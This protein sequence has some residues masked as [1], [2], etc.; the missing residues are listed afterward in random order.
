MGASSLV[1]CNTKPPPTAKDEKGLKGSIPFSSLPA[2]PRVTPGADMALGAG[3]G[4]PRPSSGAR[5]PWLLRASPS[6][7]LDEKHAPSTRSLNPCQHE[8]P[9]LLRAARV[10]CG[11]S[12]MA[13]G[14]GDSTLKDDCLGNAGTDV[15][16]DIL[17][18]AR[19]SPL[20]LS[21]RAER[22]GERRAGSATKM[23]GLRI[24]EPDQR[25]AC[26]RSKGKSPPD[27]GVIDDQR[28]SVGR[29]PDPPSCAGILGRPSS[30]HGS[31]GARRPPRRSDTQRGPGLG[32]KAWDAGLEDAG[33]FLGGR[34]RATS[35]ET[36]SPH[37]GLNS[38]MSAICRASRASA[39]T[40]S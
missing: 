33:P 20:M 30:E 24:L 11:I 26:L 23:G 18:G 25:L 40:D 4:T 19:G 28:Q 29:I 10:V 17:N 9:R 15:A 31:A 14:R 2:C 1:T 22:V 39:G 35:A 32:G 38:R 34:V 16:R 37:T 3:V 21:P 36:P 8:I 13:T 5:L 27:E 6:A 7:T 12:R